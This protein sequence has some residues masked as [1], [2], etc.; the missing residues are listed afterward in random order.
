[1][2]RLAALPLAHLQ[3]VGPSV[4]IGQRPS[5]LQRDRGAIPDVV[6]AF[7]ARLIRC[8]P[9]AD[10]GFKRNDSGGFVGLSQSLGWRSRMPR[11]LLGDPAV[12]KI[13]IDLVLLEAG[14]QAVG[15]EIKVDIP[16]TPNG[17]IDRVVD[18]RSQSVLF[19]F[20]SF[21]V[22]LASPEGCVIRKLKFVGTT[23]S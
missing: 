10:T 2:K 20:V 13:V 7:A 12:V 16:A 6:G 19:T 5:E 4:A 15:I 23:A 18:S 14:Y 21:E 8:R 3:S 1:M 17:Q 22:A 11:G 9:L